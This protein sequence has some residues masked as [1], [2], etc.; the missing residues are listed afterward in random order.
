MKRLLSDYSIVLQIN[1]G[2]QGR[3]KQTMTVAINQHINTLSGCCTNNETD[4][5]KLLDVLV[6]TVAK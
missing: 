5:K 4:L 6:L 3:T 1:A 2:A